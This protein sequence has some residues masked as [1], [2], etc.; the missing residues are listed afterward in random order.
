MMIEHCKGR[1]VYRTGQK[2]ELYACLIS[3]GMQLY[4]HC[5]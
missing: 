3:T 2:K 4:T 1:D 5:A